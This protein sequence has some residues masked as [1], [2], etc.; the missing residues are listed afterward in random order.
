MQRELQRELE[1]AELG[2]RPSRREFSSSA[3]SGYEF[4]DIFSR[5]LPLFE[6]YFL[7]RQDFIDRNHLQ[8]YEGTIHYTHHK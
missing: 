7:A 8:R 4:Y 3:H 2:V 1:Q 5:P 6:K